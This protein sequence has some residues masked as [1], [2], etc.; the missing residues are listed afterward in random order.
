VGEA[1]REVAVV[2]G[3]GR[4]IGR[5]IAVALAGTGRHVVINFRSRT[6]D[7]TDTL[8]LVN[9]AGGTG[10][11]CQF[12][13]AN[14]EATTAAVEDILKRHG[15][16]DI[17]VNNAGIRKDALLIWT[18]PEEWQSVIDTNLTGFYNATR[19]ILKDMLLRR[20]GRIV[21]ISSTSGMSGMPGQVHYS[22]AKAGLIAATQAL[23]R[24]VA[25]RSITVNAVAPGFIDT[26]MLK[27]LPVEEL[28]KMVPMGRLGTPRE[29][30]ALVVFLCSP[31]ASYITGQVIGVNGGVI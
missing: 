20:S 18:Q 26:E 1:V 27:G 6:G 4:G 8:R 11:L 21:N 10:E 2:T 19:P 5:A 3:A 16:V 17:L 22:A 29:V 14:H 9:E 15:R 25:K 28:V 30:A 13:V 31:A 24:E 7:A 23:A 12:D